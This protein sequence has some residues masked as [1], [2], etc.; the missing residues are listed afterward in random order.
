MRPTVDVLL[1]S[2]HARMGL[3]LT[4]SGNVMELVTVLT[5]VMRTSVTSL[6]R[7][8]SSSAVMETSSQDP[9]NVMALLTVQMGRMSSTA[10]M[11]VGD[12]D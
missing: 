5:T 2:S 9:S 11:R 12:I 7:S 4:G 1:Y 10:K 3:V 6:Q 8:N